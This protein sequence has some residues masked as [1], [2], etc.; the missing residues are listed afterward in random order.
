MDADQ[1]VITDEELLD[2]V[3]TLSEAGYKFTLSYNPVSKAATA[4]LQAGDAH[5][6]LVGWALSA[7]GTDGRDAV[8]MLLYKHHEC[9]K[10]DWTGLLTAEKPVQRG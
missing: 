7:R 2:G 10:G 3:I 8:K 5:P 1:A 6:K 9:L 4:T